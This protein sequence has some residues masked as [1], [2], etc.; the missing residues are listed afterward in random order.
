MSRHV[1]RSGAD[2]AWLNALSPGHLP[3][4]L[5]MDVLA[6]E[7]GKLRAS[8]L[9]RPEMLAPNG[10]LHAATVVAL[11]DTAAGYATLAHL[12]VGADGFTTIELKTNFFGTLTKGVLFCEATAVH[13]GRTTQVW[14]AEVSSEDGRRLA[15][16]RC[17]QMVLWP[18]AG[19]PALTP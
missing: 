12:P 6:I 18:K 9:I 5:G 15:L 10:F 7:P 19:S 14:D 17:T 11:A 4:W 1:L 13:S 3:G 8:L 2:C 16:F